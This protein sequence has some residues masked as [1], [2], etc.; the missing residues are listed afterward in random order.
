M[1]GPQAEFFPKLIGGFGTIRGHPNFEYIGTNL[2]LASFEIRFPFLDALLLGFPVPWIFPG[3][4]GVLFMDFGTIFYDFKSFQGYDSEEGR[5]K[6]LKL[7]IGLG[8]RFLVFSGIYLKI[9]WA[10][11]WDFKSI[12]PL[13][14]WRGQFSIGAEF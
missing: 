7:S 12:L 14:L 4:S 11:P 6:D 2:F 9:N 10:T 13:R 1:Q 5:L 3:F 8:A